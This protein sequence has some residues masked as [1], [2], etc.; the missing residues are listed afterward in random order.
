MK[1]VG[2]YLAVSC[3]L[4]LSGCVQP[5]QVDLIE[6]EQRRLR[7][8][9]TTVQSDVGT[10]RSDIDAM[11]SSLADTRATVQQQQRE[12]SALEARRGNPLSNGAALGQS[13]REGDQR[14]KDLEGASQNLPMR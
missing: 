10:L 12:L 3:L 8:D 5:Q 11:R 1:V 2:R 7:S 9:S 14:V 6:R 13:S 4:W